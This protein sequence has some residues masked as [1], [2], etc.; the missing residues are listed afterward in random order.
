MLYA[1]YIRNYYLMDTLTI[2]YI[3]SGYHCYFEHR[4]KFSNYYKK[5]YMYLHD[6]QTS[7]SNVFYLVKLRIRS[8]RTDMIPNRF[9]YLMTL[10]C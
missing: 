8:S 5:D 1:F 3:R 4:W 9:T 10:K 6:L 7:G 2:N